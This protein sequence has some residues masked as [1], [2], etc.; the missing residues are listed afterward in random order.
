MDEGTASRTSLDLAREAEQMGTSLSTSCGWDGSCISFQCLTP[1]LGPSLDLAVDVLRN[2]TF[3]ASEW[4]R[5]HGQTLAALKA[6]RDSAEARAHRGLLR[7]LYAADHPYHLPIDGE[8][9][10]VAR[11]MRDDLQRFHDRHHG[12]SGAACVVAGDVA[13]D[14]VA[15]ALDERL[16]G[17]TGPEAAAPSW[18]T[19][20]GA[21]ARAFCCSTGPGRLRRPSGWAT[22]GWRGSTPTT[23]TC[24][25]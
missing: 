18:L 8:E 4:E 1:Y 19:L 5:I 12:P 3:P 24:S 13:P 7:A 21:T 11:L 20:R 17:W 23:P 2:P 10:I 16:A 6:E 9:L 15:E 14:H 22:S 25:S